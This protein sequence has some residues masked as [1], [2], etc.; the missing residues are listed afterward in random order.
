MGGVE[1]RSLHVY[2]QQEKPRYDC[3]VAMKNQ[4]K[5]RIISAALLAVIFAFFIHLDALRRGRLGREVFLERQG[6]RY[7]RHYAHPDSFI[8]EIPVGIV[9]VGGLYGVYE[10]LALG[11]F[12]VLKAM[13]PDKSGGSPPAA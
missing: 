10:L 4:V 3:W 13:S 2:A 12:K 8:S 5:S 11:V 1:E 7:D 6:E 9:F